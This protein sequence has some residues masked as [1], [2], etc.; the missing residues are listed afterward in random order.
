MSD[1]VSGVKAI[2]HNK[3]C[4]FALLSDLSNLERIKEV[5]RQDGRLKFENLTC[6]ADSCSL[7]LSAVGRVGL[8]VTERKDG[9]TIKFESENSPVPLHL[10]IQLKEVSAEDTRLR[11]TVRTELSS[12]LLTMLSGRLQEGIEQLADTLAGLPYADIRPLANIEKP[13]EDHA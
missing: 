9:E 1:F 7:T 6:D 2:P 11:L 10:W 12:F 4:V 8:R 5:V 13:Y 3:A